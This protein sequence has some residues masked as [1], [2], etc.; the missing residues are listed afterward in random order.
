MTNVHISPEQ[1]AL[2]VVSSSSSALSISEKFDLY[3]NAY[4]F[5]LSKNKNPK[6]DEAT[7]NLKE[8]N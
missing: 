7:E 2:A 8:L 4:K 5:A 3:T 6:K 1:F